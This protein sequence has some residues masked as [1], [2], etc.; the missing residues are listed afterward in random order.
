MK[1]AQRLIFILLALGLAIGSYTLAQSDIPR[2][3][4]NPQMDAWAKAAKLG[5]YE[6]EQDWDEIIAKAKEEGEVIIYSSSSRMASVGETFSKVYPEIKVTSFDLGS[7]K[8]FEKTV[9]EQEAGIYNADIITT[10]GSGNFIYDLIANNR[11]VNFVPS[12]FKDRIAPE[13]REPALV[14]IMEAIVFMYNTE[15]N[16]APPISN[17]WELT[18]E[19]YRGKVVIK[20]PLAS[21]SNL[22]GVATIAQHADEM[23]AAYKE[24]TGEDI[25]LSD[26]VPDAG[27]E[28]LYRLLHNDLI[29]LDS[30]SKTTGSSGKSGQADPP[31]S[32]TS[33]TYLRYNNTK[34]YVN[35][36]L[37]PV[38]PADG[39]IYPTYTAIAARA[40]HPNA[41]KLF[42]AFMLGDPDITLDTVIEKPYT[43]GAALETLQGLAPYYEIGSVSPRLD[44]PL[45]QGGEAWNEMNMW[46]VDPEYMWFDAP[47]VQDFWIR[48]SA[49]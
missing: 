7:V 32:I 46:V 1:K 37:F 35:G 14:R 3:D 18:T 41:A 29:I 22:M 36:I 21:L 8:T 28:F 4:Y 43:E 24:M 33:F 10:G 13:N 38:A 17:M 5:P 6:G 34:E 19:A 49:R 12:M 15:V 48:E 11:V 9:G 47:K 45:P 42:T 27:Y 20:D 31:V 16:D 30:G 25:V 44:V 26:G 23:A 40:P 2:E 39:V